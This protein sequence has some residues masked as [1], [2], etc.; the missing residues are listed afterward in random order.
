[1]KRI[2]VQFTNVSDTRLIEDR[3]DA[4]GAIL[5]GIH[6][7]GIGIV[8]ADIGNLVDVEV[9]TSGGLVDS[10]DTELIGAIVAAG[11][12]HIERGD[13]LAGIGQTCLGGGGERE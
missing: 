5:I 9:S 12:T 8:G 7:S 11:I 4:V 2:S 1:M 10:S 13:F 6:G 3:G